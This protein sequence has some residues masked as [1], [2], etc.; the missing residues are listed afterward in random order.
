MKL[1]QLDFFDGDTL[2]I[3]LQAF[4]YER[5]HRL[6]V[7]HEIFLKSFYRLAG[8]KVI[9]NRVASPLL[10]TFLDRA[11]EKHFD[12]ALECFGK[13]LQRFV[14]GLLGNLTLMLIIL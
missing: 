12:F 4:Y 13:D 1:R 3:A 11:V 6:M 5:S 8:E 10:Q 7:Q 2:Q 9:D 14:F